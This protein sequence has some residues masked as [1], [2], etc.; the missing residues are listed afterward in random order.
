MRRQHTTPSRLRLLHAL[1]GMEQLPEDTIA[2]I[3]RLSTQAAVPAGRVLMRQG[4]RGRETFVIVAGTA[5][6]RCDE[7]LVAVASAG[8]VVGEAA[9]LHGGGRSADVIA[10]TDLTLLVTSPAELS[11]LYDDEAFRAWLD[12]QVEA[13]ATVRPSI[14]EA[15][16]HTDSH[17]ATAK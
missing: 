10:L 5:A 16:G 2:R 8:S 13:R 11:S 1:P 4:T 14:T 6:V 7:T 3:D 17:R 12:R 15:I 9:V